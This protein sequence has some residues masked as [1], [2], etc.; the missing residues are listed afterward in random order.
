MFKKGKKTKFFKEFNSQHKS[1]I[2]SQLNIVA[3]VFG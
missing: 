3:E 1:T 2:E